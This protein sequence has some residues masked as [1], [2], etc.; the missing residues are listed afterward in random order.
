MSF[1]PTFFLG[2]VFFQTALSCCGGYHL[3]RGGMPLHHAVGITCRKDATTENQ[4][5][6]VK[7]MGKG[8]ML[9][10]VCVLS[11]LI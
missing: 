10:I 1:M 8:S 9:M 4:G 3:E 11:G 7:Y 6:D 5:V 2:H